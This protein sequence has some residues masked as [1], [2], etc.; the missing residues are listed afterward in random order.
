MAITASALP[1]VWI[2]TIKHAVSAPERKIVNAMTLQVSGSIARSGGVSA[3]GAVSEFDIRGPATLH[4]QFLAKRY[5]QLG[6]ERYKTCSMVQEQIN[7][8]P[9][10]ARAV[11]AKAAEDAGRGELSNKKRQA[12][13]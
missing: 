10:A 7:R 3:K 13:A 2:L 11:F 5:Q 1:G 8:L 4:A 12:E 6:V 9:E